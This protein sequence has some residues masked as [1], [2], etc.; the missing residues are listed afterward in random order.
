MDFLQEKARLAISSTHFWRR[1]KMTDY[2]LVNEP[3]TRHK[4]VTESS[5]WEF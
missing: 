1:W 2:I 4:K 5:Q 3:Q